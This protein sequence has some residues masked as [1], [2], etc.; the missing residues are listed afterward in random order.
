MTFGGYHDFRDFRPGRAAK[1]FRNK[2]P[3]FHD[4]AQVDLGIDP[5]FLRT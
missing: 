4:P 3:D 5:P 1:L 2:Q